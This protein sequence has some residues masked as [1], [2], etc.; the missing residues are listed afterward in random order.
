MISDPALVQRIREFY[1]SHR[2]SGVDEDQLAKY[3]SLAVVLT[4]PPAFKPVAREEA[5][6]DDARSVLGFVPLLQEFFRKSANFETVGGGWS[7]I[8][9]A[10]GSPG[11]IDSRSYRPYRLLS[12]SSVRRCHEPNDEGRR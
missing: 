6:P 4:D 10:D 11:P 9:G 12:P 3:I 5:L 1:S 7:C 2:P 8:R